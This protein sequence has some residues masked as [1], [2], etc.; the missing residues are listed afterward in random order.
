MEVLILSKTELND[1]NVIVGGMVLEDKQSVRLLNAEGWHPC[2][3]TEYQ[4]GQVWEIDFLKPGSNRDPHNEDVIVQSPKRYIRS[5]DN[6]AQFI[7]QSGVTIWRGSIDHLFGNQLLWAEAGA[8]YI[9]GLKRILPKQSEG[10]WVNDRPLNYERDGHY[11]YL[12]AHGKAEKKKLKYK[13]LIPPPASIPAHT[14]LRVS[15]ARWWAP[16]GSIDEKRCYLLLSG[17][18]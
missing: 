17:W 15:L 2:S 16:E 10:F 9:S 6:L 13:G 4:V 14:L 8:G 1:N 7:R 11:L 12:T 18:Y 5:I 3:D